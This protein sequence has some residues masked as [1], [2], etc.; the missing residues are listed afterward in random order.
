M[1]ELKRHDLKF[2]IGKRKTGVGIPLVKKKKEKFF[3]FFLI[4]AKDSLLPSPT[5][6]E[7]EHK[8]FILAQESIKFPDFVLAKNDKVFY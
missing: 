7:F 2:V 1:A 8:H 6:N 4:K 3:C 5:I